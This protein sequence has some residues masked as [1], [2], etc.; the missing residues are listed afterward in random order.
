M[1]RQATELLHYSASD[2]YLPI[3]SEVCERLDAIAPFDSLRARSFLT[4]SGTEA[5]E[6]AH[7]ARALRHRAPVPDRLLPVVPRPV[8]GQRLA[9]RVQGQVPHR[10]SGRCCRRRA[11]TRST[12]TS[13]TSR[14]CC[15]KRVSRPR[16]SRPI[17]VESWLGRGRLRPAARRLVPL[18]PR[19]LRQARHPA[20]LRR[21]AVGDGPQ[22]HD[23]GDRAGGRRA[24]HHHRRQ[25]H[26]ERAA[27]RRDDRPRRSHEVGAGLARVH[28][29]RQPHLLRGGARDLRRDPGGGAPGERARRGRGLPGGVPGDRRAPPHHAGGARACADGSGCPSRTTTRRSRWSRPR[30]PRV[31]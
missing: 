22:R 27:A 9:H 26:R 6:A 13:T 18:P 24:R 25:G 8:D 30:S 10:T 23:V 21:G 19:A 20:D 15:F 29:R 12:A 17:V 11:T 4:N 5:V 7:Q 3:Y 2:F 28:L 1:S 14:T 31:C 16:R